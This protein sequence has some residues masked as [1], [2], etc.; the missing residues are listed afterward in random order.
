MG[1]VP[2]LKLFWAGPVKKNTLLYSL[3]WHV[4]YLRGF[5]I[6]FSW[7]HQWCLIQGRVVHRDRALCGKCRM[8][9]GKWGQDGPKSDALLI[10]IWKYTVEKSQIISRQFEEK[11]KV[12]NARCLVGN[13]VK[14]GLNQ[15]LSILPG[16]HQVHLPKLQNVV[17]LIV[18]SICSNCKMYLS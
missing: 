1:P 16:K 14:M 9:G 8:L 6:I 5:N 10:L 15:M 2:Y 11:V 13:G 17:F 7:C 3:C 4:G 12:E 18:K